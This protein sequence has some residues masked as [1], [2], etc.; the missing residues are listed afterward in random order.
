MNEERNLQYWL[1]RNFDELRTWAYFPKTKEAITRAGL[2][3]SANECIREFERHFPNKLSF[4]KKDW[5]KAIVAFEGIHDDSDK[6]TASVRNEAA[7]LIEELNSLDST[8][9]SN[10]YGAGLKQ[11]NISSKVLQIIDSELN[12]DRNIYKPSII[13]MQNE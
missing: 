10:F 2:T 9:F 7:E 8:T 6:Q 11:F 4:L 12:V 13:F 1:L 5:D 3:T